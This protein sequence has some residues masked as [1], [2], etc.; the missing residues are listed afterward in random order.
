MQVITKANEGS[1]LDTL[2]QVGTAKEKK[3]NKKKPIIIMGKG[4]DLSDN[5]ALFRKGKKK[6]I[7]QKIVLSLSDVAKRKGN[8]KLEKLFW[9]TFYCQNF[10]TSAEGRLYSNYCK[11][12]VCS[13]CAGIRK[14]KKIKELLP[15]VKSWDQPYFVTLTARSVY[16]NKLGIRMKKMNIGLRKILD[17]YKKKAQRGKS[18][19]FEGFKTLEC[20]FNSKKR[21]YN[22]HLHLIVKNKEMAEIIIREW[23]ILCT[24]KFALPDGQKAIPVRDVEESLIEVIKYSTK[25]F[26]DPD[27]NNKKG[28]ASQFVYTSAMFNILSAMEGLRTFEKFGFMISKSN[29]NESNYKIVNETEEWEYNAEV[30]DWLNSKHQRL[31]GYSA[32]SELLKMLTNNINSDLE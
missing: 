9:N 12:K 29:R 30:L 20:N 19:K 4:S 16:A 5:E 2:A 18:I 23:L 28:K 21:T 24:T 7:T 6:L 17:K 15:I 14:A 31:T 25:Q 13:V 10:V 11:N 26:T 22:P 1:K 32:T 27:P 8:K 3:E